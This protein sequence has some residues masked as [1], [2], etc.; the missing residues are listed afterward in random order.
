MRVRRPV[1]AVVCLVMVMAAVSCDGRSPRLTQPGGDPTDGWFGMR[2]GDVKAGD[3]VI[4]NGEIILCVDRPGRVQIVN[5]SMKDTDA[6]LRV[7]AFAVRIFGPDY[8]DWEK[9]E[10][11]LWELGFAEGD[12][13][14]DVV[15]PKDNDDQEEKGNPDRTQNHSQ[16]VQL[17]LQL[18][19]PSDATAR[20]STMVISYVPE[21][22]SRQR[23]LEIPMGLVLCEGQTT[24]H[25][26]SVVPECDF[27][28]D[29]Y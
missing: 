28:D 14:V 3:H 17:G 4:L 12:L 9:D 11:T 21:G 25:T 24:D 22:R 16:W 10:Q 15:C 6:E 8:P 13:W 26:G 2:F 19:K 1:A 20:G 23:T 29:G 18:S 27:L 7:D 5:V